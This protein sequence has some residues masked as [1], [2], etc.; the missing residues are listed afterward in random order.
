MGVEIERK[1]L[2]TTLPQGL[3][4][5][6]AGEEILQGYLICDDSR[7][8][9][10]RKRAGRY[11]MTVKRGSGLTR[12]EEEQPI[13]RQLFDML[14]PLTEN[15]RIEKVRY[16][17]QQGEHLLEIDIFKGAL[18]PLILLEVEF[19]DAAASADFKVPGFIEKEVTDD[20]NCKNSQLA[21]RHIS[22]KL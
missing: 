20:K 10:L 19:A 22:D 14:W 2:I 7:E 8:L 11:L 17:L 15:R 12:M 18:A 13:D 1:F 21:N 9:R 16:C 4:N 6:V 3:L 5:G